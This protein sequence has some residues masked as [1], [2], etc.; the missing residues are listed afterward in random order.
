MGTSKGPSLLTTSGSFVERTMGALAVTVFSSCYYYSFLYPITV[1]VAFFAMPLT[2]AVVFAAPLFLSIVVPAKRLP[3]VLASPFFKCALK[4]HDF[5]EVLETPREELDKL[6]AER[7]LIYAVQPHG[8]M[9][10]AGICYAIYQAPRPTPPTCVAS[11][12]L[13]VP[14]LKHVFGSFGLISASS[15]SLA[16][17]L[18]K[19]SVVLYIGG[20]AELFLSTPHEERLY[21]AKRKG[22]IKMA[23]R[24]GT[25]VVPSYYFGNTTVL[26]V[27][28]CV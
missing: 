2:F 7:R 22:F 3:G 28:L 8:V 24:T 21:A 19:T 20:M 11:V 27:C 5:E 15:R 1:L 12:I 14:I 26:E 10:V 23:M 9:S 18:S 17:A 13:Q 4:Y 6:E 25:D 16:R